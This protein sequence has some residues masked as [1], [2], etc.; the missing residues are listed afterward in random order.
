[1]KHFF[2]LMLALSLL[3]STTSHAI[4]RFVDPFL[5][6]GNGS[7]LFT[8]I[9]SAVAAS[10]NGD[11]ILIVSANYAEPTLTI[12][13]SLTLLS[14]TQGTL[15]NFNGNIVIAGFAG[16]KLELLGFD[17]GIYSI[18]SNAISG[19]LATNRAKLSFIEC[20]MANLSV[21]QNYYEMNAIRCIMT[22]NSIFRFGNFIASKT[23][24][25]YLNDEPNSNLTTAKILI[26]A[27]TI[28]NTLEIR[29][30][31]YPVTIANCKLTSLYFWMWNNV[32]TNTNF[33]RNNQFSTGSNLSFA[34]SGVP[35]YNIEFSSNE[36]PS[37]PGF[38][39]NCNGYPN[40]NGSF[41]CAGWSSV[42]S[43]FPNVGITGFFRWTYNGINLPCST[44]AGTDPLVLTRVVGP[45]G[46]L[47]N[48]GNPTHDYYDTDLTINDRG[49]YGG[50]YSLNNYYPTINTSNG[51]AFIFDLE[52][53]ADLFSGQQVDIKAKGYHRN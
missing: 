40:W 19:G 18:S 30:D 10:V 5:S 13:K 37:A 16:M 2:K 6:N 17:L 38:I 7:T 1:M 41:S 8:T 20:K 26:A 42:G 29:N 22:G 14:Q 39:S 9:S 53:P 27:D 28:T 31:D 12:N 43:G 21:D 44:P 49:L 51:R 15:V 24:F 46:T 32:L 4:D 45:T 48:S 25:L 52:I 36:F 34:V 50:P 3:V 23:N 33:I 35:N 11:R 47:V